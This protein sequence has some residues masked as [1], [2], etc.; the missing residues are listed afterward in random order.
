MG[1]QAERKTTKL[2][3]KSPEEKLDELNAE[4]RSQPNAFR[5]AIEADLEAK[6]KRKRKAEPSVSSSFKSRA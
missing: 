2:T 6:S 4:L 3:G 1:K 5:R